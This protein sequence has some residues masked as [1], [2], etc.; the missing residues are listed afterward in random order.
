MLSCRFKVS[1]GV[2]KVALQD[3]LLQVKVFFSPIRHHVAGLGMVKVWGLIV[4]MNPRCRLLVL[5]LT[6]K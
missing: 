6:V 4:L 3:G 1:R 5:F 2:E